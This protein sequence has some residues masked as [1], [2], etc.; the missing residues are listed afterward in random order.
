MDVW[1]LRLYLCTD[2]ALLKGR[3]LLEAVEEAIS[4]GVTIVQLRE[5][6][7]SGKE[8][9]YLAREMLSLT[10]RYNVPLIINDRLDIA[11]AVGAAGVHLGQDDLPLAAARRITEKDFI[12]GVSAHNREEALAAEQDG[13]DYLGTGAMFPTGTKADAGV[14][15]PR[16]L[17][18]VASTVKI[19]VVGIGGIGSG[20]IAEVMT[21]GAAGAAVISAILSRDD[22]HGAAAELR[23]IIDT[24][25]TGPDKSGLF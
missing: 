14:I 16:R 24:F 15:G 3:N 9:F 2:N 18:A 10:S 21:S 5:K 7:L 23:V 17:A 22:I 13:A 4:G 20:N 8:F 19:P 6:E 25:N 11:L 1:S 12:I